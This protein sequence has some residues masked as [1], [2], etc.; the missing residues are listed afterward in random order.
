MIDADPRSDALPESRASALPASPA[1]A[2]MQ[3]VDTSRIPFDEGS[4]EARMGADV[5]ERAA[6]AKHAAHLGES[7]FWVIEVGVGEQRDDGVER[8]VR[9]RQPARV[10]LDEFGRHITGVFARDSQLIGRDV[11]ADHGPA[12]PGKVRNGDAGTAPEVEALARTGAEESSQ[13]LDCSRRDAHRAD[14]LLVPIRQTVVSRWAGHKARIRHRSSWESEL[15]E[16]VTTR[17]AP[18]PVAVGRLFREDAMTPYMRF[19]AIGVLLLAVAAVLAASFLVGLLVFW[20]SALVRAIWRFARRGPVKDRGSL[21]DGSIGVDPSGWY[22][23][24]QYRPRQ[25]DDGPPGP[26]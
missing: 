11:N 17:G 24:S 8:L 12:A 20:D 7:T 10:S 15:R 4:N 3:N 16:A 21:A 6:G 25:R 9:K 23:P 19:Q 18:K 5:N 2:G 14:F 26:G 22:L 13:S 1:I